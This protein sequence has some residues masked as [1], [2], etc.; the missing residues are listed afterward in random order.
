MSNVLTESTER[1]MDIRK[2]KIGYGYYEILRDGQRVATV[3]KIV[4]T[5]EPIWELTILDDTPYRKT[6]SGRTI[7][8]GSSR[9]RSISRHSALRSAARTTRSSAR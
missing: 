6:R 5:G 7:R 4:D 2:K 3:D 8:A 9:S 1:Q